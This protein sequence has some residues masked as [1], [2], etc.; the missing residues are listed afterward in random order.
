[1]DERSQIVL[2][3]LVKMSKVLDQRNVARKLIRMYFKKIPELVKARKDT[4]SIMY[5]LDSVT[6]NNPSL[7]QVRF[8]VY[9]PMVQGAQTMQIAGAYN[10]T[11]ENINIHMGD[12]LKLPTLDKM[13]A[14]IEAEIFLKLMEPTLAHELTHREQWLKIKDKTKKLPAT[15]KEFLSILNST[16]KPT[17]YD[18]MQYKVKDYKK[19]TREEYLSRKDELMTHASN[20]I[21][22]FRYHNYTYKEILDFLKHPQ[23]VAMKDSTTFVEYRQLFG[24]DS[25]TFKRLLKYILQFTQQSMR[26]KAT[27]IISCI[28]QEPLNKIAFDKMVAAIRLG[29]KEVIEPGTDFTAS[30]G[31]TYLVRYEHPESL[32]LLQL[33]RSTHI[34]IKVDEFEEKFK[35]KTM[36]FR[37]SDFGGNKVVLDAIRDSYRYGNNAKRLV[38]RFVSEDMNKYKYITKRKI[39]LYGDEHPSQGITYVTNSTEFKYIKYLE[40]QQKIERVTDVSNI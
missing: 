35:R 29:P 17:L 30:D 2:H 28:L 4:E 32:L 27:S 21:S 37:D 26:S 22:E 33:G 39:Y 12:L 1:M 8:T 23:K 40:G 38:D 9:A 34:V 14:E 25:D 10:P 11:S 31:E 5:I 19:Q 20:C 15:D 6:E 24:L 16:D 36:G 18:Q 3:C 7:P 13:S